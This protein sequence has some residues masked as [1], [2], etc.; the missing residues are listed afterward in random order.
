MTRTSEHMGYLHMYIYVCV[1][2]YSFVYLM[3]IQNMAMNMAQLYREIWA[4]YPIIVKWVCLQTHLPSFKDAPQRKCLQ[5]KDLLCCWVESSRFWYHPKCLA[6]KKSWTG[7]R[8][9]APSDFQCTCDHLRP[10][11]GCGCP[12][13]SFSRNLRRHGFGART[14]RWQ[15]WLCQLCPFSVAEMVIV[16]WL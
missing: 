13:E 4:R 7:L 3:V 11:L 5:I 12:S 14:R 8:C 2:I 16:W 6:G 9:L 15:W 1:Y 10:G